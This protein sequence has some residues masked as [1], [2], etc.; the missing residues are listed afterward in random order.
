MVLKR[1]F[2]RLVTFTATGRLTAHTKCRNEVKDLKR[3]GKLCGRAGADNQNEAGDGSALYYDNRDRVS[4][5]AR[6]EVHNQSSILCSLH[7]CAL[8]RSPDQV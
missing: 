4:Q 6:S 5:P 1:M 3:S 8:C 2:P 7:R